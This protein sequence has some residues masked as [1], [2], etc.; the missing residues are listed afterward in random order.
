M[1]VE[2]ADDP[3]DPAIRA[4]NE[5]RIWA[6][7]PNVRQMG[8]R[9]VQIIR[10]EANEE[11]LTAL[12]IANAT[13][14]DSTVDLILSQDAVGAQSQLDLLVPKQKELTSKGLTVQQAS[15]QF[16]GAASRVGA[17]FRHLYLARLALNATE[18]AIMHYKLRPARSELF[19]L[20]F[21]TREMIENQPSNRV[22]VVNKENGIV[23]G[24]ITYIFRR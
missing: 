5:T 23:T 17:S 22:S 1:L 8:L 3:I 4:A 19:A 9:N 12:R 18:G 7:I 2:S 16:R 20:I 10:P 21:N 14:S 11:V 13:A 15:A 6:L 24:G